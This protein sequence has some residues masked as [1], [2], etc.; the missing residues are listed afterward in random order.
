VP[1]EKNL[2]HIVTLRLITGYSLLVISLVGLLG[3]DWDI[4]WHATVGRDRTF[5]PPHDMILIGLALIGIV[6]LINILVETRWGGHNH[7]LEQNSTDF[8]GMI[9]SSL[10]SYIVGFG[11]VCSAVAFPLDTYWHSLYGIDVSLWAPFHTMLYMG[12]VLSTF[13]IAYIFLSTA[14]I[15]QDLQRRWQMRLGYAGVIVTLG[16]LLSKSC[17]FLTPALQGHSLNL[18]FGAISLFPL[19]LSVCVSFV[20]ILAVR[21]VRWPGTATLTIITFVA[22]YLL[23]NA[24]VPPMMTWLVQAEH[25][26]YLTRAARLGS[27]VVPLLGQSPLLLLTGLSID[28]AILLGK[29]ARWSLSTFNWEIAFAA[30][31]S[32]TIGAALTFVVLGSALARG[33]ATPGGQV[34][35]AFL[36]SL[37]LAVLGGLLGSWLGTKVST[38]VQDL[39]R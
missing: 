39:R 5:T 22:V 25:Q 33:Q 11:A 3:G 13:G 21:I 29:R 38:T 20:C 16:T 8:L 19:L 18:G 15:A 4:Q 1:G 26:T 14:H 9:Q 31:V 28:G 37:A 17:T 34:G 24:F 32:T 30:A 23:V 7:E 12:G 36:L 6:A 2:T 10:G 27:H 35:I